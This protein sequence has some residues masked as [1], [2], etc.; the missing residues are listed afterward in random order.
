MSTL[1]FTP[2]SF[3]YNGRVAIALVPSLIVAAALGGKLVMGVLTV[4][5]MVAYILDALQYREGSFT[6]VWSTLALADVGL[7]VNV[8]LNSV[9]RPWILTAATILTLG[10]LFVLAGMWATLQFQWIQMRYPAVA[11]VFER[12]VIT[13]SIPVA[14][15]VQTVGMASL[16]EVAD[17][18]YYMAGVLLVLYSALARPLVSSFHAGGRP[19]AAIG[20]KA[21]SSVIIQTAGDAFLLYLITVMLPAVL[22]IAL[23]LPVLHHWVHISGLMLT[24]AAPV[25]LLCSIRNGMWWL[26][27]SPNLADGL[28]KTLLVAAAVVALVGFEGRVVFH[29][30]GQYIQLQAPYNYIAVTLA[31]AGFGSV[32]VAHVTGYL[33][34]HFD[35]TL[36]GTAMLLCTTAGGLAAGGWRRGVHDG[37]MMPCGA[38]VL[39]SCCTCCRCDSGSRA[40]SCTRTT[41]AAPSQRSM[42]QSAASVITCCCASWLK[43]LPMSSAMHTLTRH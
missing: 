37:A 16:V 36:A 31:L 2:N 35:V 25:V 22:Y 5:C 14:A 39:A 9:G 4:G 33:E 23:H 42:S 30:F 24:S 18:P 26:P 32:F 41:C 19:S 1:R 3:L 21:S 11:V 17:V 27:G 40:S 43:L 20:G 29:S 34:S 7:V 13:A 12:Q 15:V 28:R 10:A 38:L 6:A 8:I